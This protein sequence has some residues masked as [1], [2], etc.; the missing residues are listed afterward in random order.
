MDYLYER[1]GKRQA[2]TAL[3][4]G[5]RDVT[6]PGLA[7]SVRGL[8]QSVQS[9]YV[10][11]VTA[12]DAL[13]LAQE[14]LKTFDDIVT[15]N[16]SRFKFGDIAEVELMRS[17]VAQLQFANSVRQAELQVNSS[18]SKLQLL[19]GRTKLQRFDVVVLAAETVL[20][21]SQAALTQAQASQEE[22]L[23]RLEVLGLT[24]GSVINQFVTVRSSVSGKVIDI[25]AVSG[26]Y[27]SDTSTPILTVAD[28]STV[29][30]AADVPEDQVRFA[31]VGNPVHITMNAYPGEVFEGRVMRIGDVV[32]STTRTVK[33]RA[34]LANPNARFRPEMFAQLREQQ[35]STEL[36]VLEKLRDVSLPDGVT[37]TLAPL[38]TPIGEMYRFTLE[39]PPGMDAMELRELEDWV[40]APRILQISGVAD[41]TPFGGVGKAISDRP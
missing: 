9:A 15:I 8:I 28:L 32:D 29:W 18:L 37:P 6:R 19:L 24:K 27:R 31:K 22:A 17:E 16:Q 11:V 40:I 13:K 5:N 20:V 2:R 33:V 4:V 39:G 35:G 41:V 14:N 26:E 3:A 1:G 7:D 21:Q 36:P 25:A 23:K 30:V 12:K 34:Q 38:S 10:D